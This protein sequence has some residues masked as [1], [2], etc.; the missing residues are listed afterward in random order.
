MT[1]SFLDRPAPIFFTDPDEFRGR[2]K[3][4][5]ALN[6]TADEL[7]HL[8]GKYDFPKSKWI[9]CGLNGC[10]T[11]HGK[12]FVFAKKNGEEGHCGRDCGQNHLGFAFDKVMAE[13]QAAVKA[14]S[15]RKRLQELQGDIEATKI[16]YERVLRLTERGARRVRYL[17]RNYIE[18]TPEVER[19][20]WSAARNGGRVNVPDFAARQRQK[21]LGIKRR[22]TDLV[23]IGSIRGYYAV[24]QYEDIVNRL[25]RRIVTLERIENTEIEKLKPKELSQLVNDLQSL[26]KMILDAEEFAK[27]AEQLTSNEGIAEIALLRKAFPPDH[28]GRIPAAFNVLEK[29]AETGLPT[30]SS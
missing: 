30:E 8:V 12:G 28:G 19:E 23:T 4:H 16:E 3:Y 26:R 29:L 6:C 14:H 17:L 10:T 9:P 2:D 13:Y 15:E 25:D 22:D 1:S 11:M 5:A 7:S 21:E 18:K 24:F 20:F 27:N